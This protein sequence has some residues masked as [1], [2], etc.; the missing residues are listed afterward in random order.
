[1][2]LSTF[3]LLQLQAENAIPKRIEVFFIYYI[4]IFQFIYLFQCIS[5]IYFYFVQSISEDVNRQLER[6]KN[7]Q[8]RFSQLQLLGESN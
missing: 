7:L 5:T 4:F 1:M 8:K 2:E 6:E 3:K